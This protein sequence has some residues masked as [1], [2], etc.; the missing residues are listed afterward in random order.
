MLSHTM[1]TSVSLTHPSTH[2]AL[3]SMSSSSHRANEPMKSCMPRMPKMSQKS[4]DTMKTLPIP[5]IDANKALTTTFSS[6]TLLITRSGLSTLIVRS[7]LTHSRPPL[8]RALEMIEM[9]TMKPS[10]QFH[11]S[12]M[13]A[14]SSQNHPFL[15]KSDPTAPYAINFIVISIAKI[16]VKT[17]SMMSRVSA[18][19]L[20]STLGLSNAIV[21][22]LMMMTN[23]MTMSNF[24]SSTTPKHQR[25]T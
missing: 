1:A 14:P 10:M 6:G 17:Q 13:Y 8:E 16:I 18:V 25:R 22:E 19:E 9:P 15:R 20:S 3:A 21:N 5:G 12:R 4:S 2:S 7:A 23:I 11:G 24:L